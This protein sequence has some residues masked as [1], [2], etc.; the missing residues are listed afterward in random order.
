[1]LQW[2][3]LRT[4]SAN[5]SAIDRLRCAAC[6]PI[7]VDPRLAFR[8]EIAFMHEFVKTLGSPVSTN[9]EVIEY[10][11]TQVLTEFFLRV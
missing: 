5:I 6:C 9:D 8:R 3:D 7:A 1:M 2:D 10:A 4:N 11:P